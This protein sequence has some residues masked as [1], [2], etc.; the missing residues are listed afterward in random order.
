MAWA[1]IRRAADCRDPSGQTREE[2]VKHLLSLA[3]SGCA[4]CTK[5]APDRVHCTNPVI[6]AAAVGVLE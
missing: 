5:L 2:C 6:G 4:R 1:M 3:L